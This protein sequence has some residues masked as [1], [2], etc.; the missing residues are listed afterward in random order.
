MT[1][2]RL[3]RAAAVAVAATTLFGLTAHTATARTPAFDFG[4]C[5]AIPAGADPAKWRCEVLVSTGTV[6]LGTLP[7]LPTGSMRLTFAEGELN[8]KYAQVFGALRSEPIRVPGGL[9]GIPDAEKNPLLRME[10]Q[11]RYA[12][13]ADF[14]SEGDRMGTQHLKLGVVSPLVGKN[15][16][17]GTDDN[18]IIFRPIRTAGPD[19]ISTNPQVLRFTI[20]DNAFAVPGPH[21]CGAFNRLLSKRLGVPARAGTNAM[22][23]TTYVA[24]RDYA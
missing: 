15:C 8:G 11:L 9:L 13:F 1:I 20:N 4:D 22:T 17:I 23:F 7:E 16:T 14:F 12:G 10:L 5:P 6:R 19:V 2:T 18:P 24:L 3:L 21:D